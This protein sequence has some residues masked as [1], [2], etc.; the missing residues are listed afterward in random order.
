MAIEAA[1]T[2]PETGDVF[3]APPTALYRYTTPPSLQTPAP[4]H[5]DFETDFVDFEPLSSLRIGETLGSGCNGDV[6]EASFQGDSVAVKQFDLSKRFDSYMN[7]V[8]AYKK[9]V[10]AWGKH[11]PKPLFVSASKSGNVRFLGMTKGRT[12]TED[13]SDASDN[14]LPKVAILERKFKFRHLDVWSNGGNFVLDEN[15][16]VLVID[17]EHWEEVV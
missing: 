17:L 9:L 4:D 2:R 12:P 7:E 13:D 5:F 14:Y 16:N 11:V 8:L 15:S 6:F 10:T 3:S 1:E